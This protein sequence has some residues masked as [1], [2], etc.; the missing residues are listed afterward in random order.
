MNR[1]AA[2]PS[3]IRVSVIKDR[4]DPVSGTD[5]PRPHDP[6]LSVTIPVPPP[7]PGISPWSIRDPPLTVLVRI[8]RNPLPDVKM[9][10]HDVIEPVGPV[11][12]RNVN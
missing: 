2:T 4:V 7:A 11:A 3:A 12:N 1:R 8:L 6:G 5:V 9:A 10:S